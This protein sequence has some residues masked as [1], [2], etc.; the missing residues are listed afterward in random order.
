M[1]S[2][3]NTKLKGT[4]MR[5]E[6]GQ[7]LFAIQ[8]TNQADLDV[9][10]IG[11]FSM[12][13]RFNNEMPATIH[14]VKL[15]VTEHHK[16]PGEWDNEE[17]Y[18]GFI[19]TDEQG[20]RYGNQYP[21]ASYGQL[22]DTSD[23]IFQRLE[24]DADTESKKLIQELKDTGKPYEYRLLSDVL[25]SMLGGIHTLTSPPVAA[26][27]QFKADMLGKLQERTKEEFEATYP[28]YKI[29]FS[30]EP[31]FLGSDVMAPKVR[32][33][34]NI[35]L[36]DI[37]NMTPASVKMEFVN[38]E[39]LKVVYPNGDLLCMEEEIGSYLLFSK[40]TDVKSIK[41]YYGEKS[42]DDKG[43]SYLVCQTQY[44]DINALDDA[45]S[46][47]MARATGTTPFRSTG[48]SFS[49]EEISARQTLRQ[50]QTRDEKVAAQ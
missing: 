47:L 7:T 33:Q 24:S 2:F 19:L 17:K 41:V 29:E 9:K 22:S 5:F 31:L 12:P 28:S 42:E 18:D 26:E 23:R 11:V 37:Q 16:V 30:E 27:D 20:N 15:T 13:M 40:M 45:V 44:F 3:P 25:E 4:I 50:S 14:F 8:F 49:L 43:I 10:R 48:I 46:C 32:I 35:S 6:I 39:R 38:S 21:R 1:V 34:R 36:T